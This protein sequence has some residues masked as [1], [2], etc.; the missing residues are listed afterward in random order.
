MAT[1]DGGDFLTSSLDLYSVSR[2]GND[3]QRRPLATTALDGS[4]PMVDSCRHVR[5]VANLRYQT[6]LRR[7]SCHWVWEEPC[8]QLSS[9]RL[10]A[11]GS[12]MTSL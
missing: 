6:G 12:A 7:W 4:R 11:C 9:E 5:V 2:F 1:V 10:K 8:R 3:V